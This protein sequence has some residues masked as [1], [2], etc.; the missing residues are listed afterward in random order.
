MVCALQ[1][2]IGSTS[3]DAS[4]PVIACESLA[5]KLPIIGPEISRGFAGQSPQPTH[6]PCRL[7]GLAQGEVSGGCAAFIAAKA[8]AREAF[9]ACRAAALAASAAARSSRSC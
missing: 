2:G 9:S 4:N 6:A 7:A 8:A 1:F 5:M 3:G